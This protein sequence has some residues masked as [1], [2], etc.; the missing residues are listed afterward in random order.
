MIRVALRGVAHC[1]NQ[2]EA[3]S[4]VR[5]LS[6]YHHWLS[7]SSSSTYV[8]WT[9]DPLVCLP[10]GDRVHNTHTRG[11][12]VWHRMSKHGGSGFNMS[13]LPSEPK[14]YFNLQSIQGVPV[15]WEEICLFFCRVSEM[16]GIYDSSR[17][18]RV[19]FAGHLANALWSN[20]TICQT[21]LSYPDV[22]LWA[23][24]W[25]MLRANLEK[26]IFLF[27]QI[28]CF[29]WTYNVKQLFTQFNNTLSKNQN[30]FNAIKDKN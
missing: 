30:S 14:A 21:T 9:V 4:R 19:V 29:I 18:A 17:I 24:C 10:P 11:R 27:G 2:E 25:L 3:E 7:N 12:Q 20:Y 1:H 6:S 22:Q 23:C 16:F 5:F 8:K 28:Q 13:C 26:Y 15:S